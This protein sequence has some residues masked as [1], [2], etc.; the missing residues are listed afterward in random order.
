MIPEVAES[1]QA[2]SPALDREERLISLCERV[3]RSLWC[4]PVDVDWRHAWAGACVSGH[5]IMGRVALV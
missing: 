1:L 2:Q 3:A 5:R 4:G